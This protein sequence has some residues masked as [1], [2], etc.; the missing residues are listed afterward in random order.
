MAAADALGWETM[1]LE[2]MKIDRPPSEASVR[3]R[4]FS[5]IDTSGFGLFNSTWI[6]Q[7]RCHLVSFNITT[8]TPQLREE[9][10]HSLEKLTSA[11]DRGEEN[12]D[13][14]C[15]KNQADTKNLVTRVDPPAIAPFLPIPVRV[16]ISRDGGVKQVNVVRGSSGQRQGI[17]TALRQWKFKPP[18]ID[19]R[20][21]EIE[22]G[23]VIQ[24]TPEGQVRYS[25]GE[26]LRGF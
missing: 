26:R 19:G 23:L 12:P 4:S 25:S 10:A 3:A 15:L 14:A 5:R 2:G 7:S 18:A 6:T 21:A 16:I 1:K 9:L 11:R 13:P 24:F 8:K 17:E 20:P 22:T